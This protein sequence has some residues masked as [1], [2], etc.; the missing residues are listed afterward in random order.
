ML[1]TYGV[2]LG[3]VRYR[4]KLHLYAKLRSEQ[5]CRQWTV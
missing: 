3:W 1:M 2:G 5:H 4:V